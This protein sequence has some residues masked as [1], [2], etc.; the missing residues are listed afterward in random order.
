MRKLRFI[1]S[2]HDNRTREKEALFRLNLANRAHQRADCFNCYEENECVKS[3]YYT[4]NLIVNKSFLKIRQN[5][6]FCM[7]R[8]RYV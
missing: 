7:V 2:V 5:F 1:K 4:N 8:T 6:I 3:K